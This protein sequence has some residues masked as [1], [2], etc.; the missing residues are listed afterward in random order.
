METFN[1]ATERLGQSYLKIGEL[2][3]EIAEKDRQL[4]RK[5]RL[6]AL[7][8]MA[9]NLAHEIRNPLGGI[10]LYVSMLRRDLDWDAAKVRTCDRILDAIS[11]LDSLVEQMLAFGREI[12]PR[13]RLQPL[14]PLVDQALELAR[15]VLEEKKVCVDL[16]VEA[17]A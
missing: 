16:S 4:A 8:R 11:G 10:Q 13:K 14:R 5:T 15:A 6:E 2:Q 12:E 7:G 9:A 1:Q 3:K 17:T